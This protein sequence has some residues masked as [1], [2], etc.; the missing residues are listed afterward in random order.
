MQSFA[1]FNDVIRLN[2]HTSFANFGFHINFWNFLLISFCFVM[3]KDSF[4]QKLL[5]WPEFSI[6]KM[7]EKRGFLMFSKTSGMKWVKKQR[8]NVHINSFM[9]EILII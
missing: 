9:M 2:E 5:L 7:S 6:K 4:K 1:T 8:K 3:K